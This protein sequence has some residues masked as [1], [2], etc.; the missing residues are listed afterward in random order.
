M[1]FG[2]GIHICL[3]AQLARQELC[4][5]LGTLLRRMR[6]IQLQSEQLHWRNNVVFRGLTS[7]P[8]TFIAS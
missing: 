4:I 1:I 3:G 8:V 7:L 2:Q 6:S 5:V